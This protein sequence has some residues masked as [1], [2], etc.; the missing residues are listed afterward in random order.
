MPEIPNIPGGEE[1]K[2]KIQRDINPGSGLDHN[3][4]KPKQAPHAAGASA[5]ATFFTSCSVEHSDSLKCIERNYQ[6]RGACEP[7]F[8]AYKACRK[9]ENE[10]RKEDNAARGWFS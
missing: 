4:G 1:I 7:F 8:K 9:D 2:K 3:Q 6:N 5:T 10:K